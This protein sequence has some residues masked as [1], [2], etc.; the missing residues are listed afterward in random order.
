MVKN[1]WILIVAK[2]KINFWELQ[3]GIVKFSK[4]KQWGWEVLFSQLIFTQRVIPV[5]SVIDIN[6]HQD[7]PN[8]FIVYFWDFCFTYL[9]P[10]CIMILVIFGKIIKL[11]KNRTTSTNTFGNLPNYVEI[12][13]HMFFIINIS[14]K[15]KITSKIKNV[16]CVGQSSF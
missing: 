14:Y 12:I 1:H 3:Y 16:F 10:A 5:I 15:K 6:P 8:N 2:N 9:A 13:L 7:V 4:M 11:I